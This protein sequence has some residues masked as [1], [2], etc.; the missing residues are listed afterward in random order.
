MVRAA[1]AGAGD[2]VW[3]IISQG[4]VVTASSGNQPAAAAEGALH[5]VFAEDILFAGPVVIVQQVL[6][7]RPPQ[8]LGGGVVL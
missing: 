5:H 4:C 7:D 2:V 3:G 1:V 8:H 6:D